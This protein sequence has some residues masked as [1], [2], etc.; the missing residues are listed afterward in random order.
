MSYSEL[1][2]EERATIQVSLSQGLSIRK[3]AALL[4]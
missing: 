1:C 4:E 3:V 2:T